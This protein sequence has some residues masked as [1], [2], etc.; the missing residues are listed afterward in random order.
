M[1]K[2]NPLAALGTPLNETT[3]YLKVLLY[4]RHGT[5]KTS[6]AASA[7]SLGTVLVINAE[8]GLNTHAL[9]ELGVPTHQILSW[10]GNGSRI[11]AA[12]LQQLHADLAAALAADPGAISAI[13]FDSITEIH[14]ILRENVTA[15]RVA[16][17]RVMVDPDEVDRR[18]Y[19]I[20]T[21]QMRRLIRLFRDLPTHIIFT[22]LEKLEESGEIRP[23]M[24]P[25]LAT[26]LMG[27][28]DLVGRTAV[29]HGHYVARFQP[30]DNLNA[31]DRTG[32]LPEIFALPTLPRLLDI[33]SGKL[34]S[35]EDSEQ[36]AYLTALNPTHSE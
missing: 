24:T 3:T 7:A 12:S 26:D 22:A 27:Y 15:D 31:K 34:D 20:M 18:D 11:T 23:A 29:S 21:V 30:T 16:K 35:T 28:V 2:A 9:S 1:A 19:N 6:A 5:G 25:A 14:H 8:G 4:G 17:A 32:T 33:T 36:S 10:Q 13:V